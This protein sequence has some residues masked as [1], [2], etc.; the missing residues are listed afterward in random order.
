MFMAAFGVMLLAELLYQSFFQYYF[1]AV[2]FKIAAA[3][4]GALLVVREAM[5]LRDTGFR[6]YFSKWGLWLLLCLFMAFIVLKNS[7]GIISNMVLFLFVFLYCA[8]TAPFRRVALAAILLSAV[9]LIVVVF[10]SS[11]GVIIDYVSAGGGRIRH[12]LGFRYALF[13]STILFNITALTVWLFQKRTSWTLLGVLTVLNLLMYSLTQSRL[14]MLTTLIVLAF[15]VVLKVKPVRKDHPVWR[16]ALSGSFAVCFFVSLFAARLFNPHVHVEAGQGY[17]ISYRLQLAHDSLHTYGITLFGRDIRWNGWNLNQAGQSA[18][19]SV[20][21]YV[22][23]LYVQGLQHY[24]VLFAILFLVLVTR[25]LYRIA[26]K[27]DWLLLAVFAVIAVHALIDD[28]VLYPHYNTFWFALA[29]VLS[30]ELAG[31]RP[32]AK[33]DPAEGSRTIQLNT[34]LPNSCPD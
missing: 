33:A 5:L 14:N 9:L 4:A 13:P 22:D 34:M 27:K 8:R 25:A 15:A 31:L 23:N 11:T 17:G 16:C 18:D 3:A 24:G 7:T 32:G 30:E 28:L 21:N 2:D 19:A 20:Y 26:E 29:P 12:Y 1:S 6:S 10:S